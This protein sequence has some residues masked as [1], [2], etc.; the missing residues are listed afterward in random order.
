MVA[1]AMTEKPSPAAAPEAPAAERS[2]LA[3][4]RFF[5]QSPAARTAASSLGRAAEVGVTF[6]DAPGPFRFFSDHGAPR[7]EAGAAKDPDFELQLAP[8]A[9]AAALS[10]L[11]H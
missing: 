10:R 9:V 11:R 4:L 1:A 3:L 6:T 7:L 8:G 2:D 5:A